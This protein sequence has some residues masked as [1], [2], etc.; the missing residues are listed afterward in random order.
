[1]AQIIRKRS[2]E[3]KQSGESERRKFFTRKG[4]KHIRT[5]RDVDRLFRDGTTVEALALVESRGLVAMP[6]PH[7]DPP[8]LPSDLSELDNPGLS[9]LL[10]E[11]RNWQQYVEDDLAMQ[12]ALLAEIEDSVRRIG[13]VIT[14]GLRGG[15]TAKA[16]VRDLDPHYIVLHDRLLKQKAL[17]TLLTSRLNRFDRFAQTVSRQITIRTNIRE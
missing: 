17:V 2:P 12:T 3:R 8:V 6:Q 9:S 4:F 10:A 13:Y 1:M 7:G 14:G 16:E 5:S 15:A 11:F